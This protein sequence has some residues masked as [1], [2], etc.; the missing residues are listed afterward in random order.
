MGDK[1]SGWAARS[2]PTV[3]RVSTVPDSSVQIPAAQSVL[4][5]LL[6]VS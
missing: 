5:V 4:N 6:D 1:L 2:P 3:G